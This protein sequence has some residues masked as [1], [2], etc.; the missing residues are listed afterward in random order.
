M[1]WDHLL[2]FKT[3]L[4]FSWT[5]SLRRC[6]FA[7]Y[8]KYSHQKDKDKFK[9]SDM[10]EK[11]IEIFQETKNRKAII[12]NKVKSGCNIFSFNFGLKF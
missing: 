1:S 6:K 11:K 9:D 7:E 12:E 3:K 8:C 5:P 4:L 2:Y 10:L